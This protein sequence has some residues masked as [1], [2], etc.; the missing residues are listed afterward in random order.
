MKF[1]EFLPS[2]KEVAF[3]KWCAQNN[4]VDI[5]TAVLC[6]P[7]ACWIGSLVYRLDLSPT[8]KVSE[9]LILNACIAAVKRIE[10]LMEDSPK[11]QFKS[12]CDY[13]EGKKPFM[14]YLK[15]KIILD[16]EFE[17]AETNS[18]KD[19]DD[20]QADCISAIVYCNNLALIGTA[21]SVAS[22]YGRQ[23]SKDSVD[24]IQG[25]Y[26]IEDRKDFLELPITDMEKACNVSITQTAEIYKTIL[27]SRIIEL[28]YENIAT[29]KPI[30]KGELCSP[31]VIDKIV[32]A[33]AI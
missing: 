20:I 1:L 6:C 10:H 9:E 31:C 23:M 26:W 24:F 12:T 3:E 21:V 5:E 15:S 14:E 2:L 4:I 27:G 8:Q 19:I 25:D 33:A 18:L 11:K 28:F 7:N 32:P 29:R 22:A 30:P 13:A 17:G 16:R